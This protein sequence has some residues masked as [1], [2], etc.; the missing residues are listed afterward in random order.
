MANGRMLLNKAHVRA[1][2][3][4]RQTEIRPGWTFDYV[5]SQAYDDLSERVRIIID[6]SL[7]RHPS[8][9]KTFRQIM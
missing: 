9:G 5:A 3:L 2:I 4:R 1:Y 8:T 7:K 6:G